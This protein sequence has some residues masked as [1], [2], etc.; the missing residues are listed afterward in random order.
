MFRG[1][2]ETK[3]GLFLIVAISLTSLAAVA[4]PASWQ[5][6][7]VPES[8][9]VAQIRTDIF[10]EDGGKP[11][12]GYGRR[13]FTSDRNANLTVQSIPNDANDTPAV[14]LAWSP[15]LA[16][17]SQAGSIAA[18]R[19]RDTARLRSPDERGGIRNH[20]HGAPDIASLIRLQA[21]T[22]PTINPVV[23]TFIYAS[24]TIS[25]ASRGLMSGE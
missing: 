10:S 7:V 23:T 6:Y 24:P 21:T 11:E 17:R 25:R 12:S 19:R 8:G 15:A 18:E 16:P 2:R 13:F 4:Q 3:P 1:I 5:Q 22:R 14:F 9:A 20:S